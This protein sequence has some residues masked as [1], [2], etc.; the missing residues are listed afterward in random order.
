[1]TPPPPFLW[2][3]WGVPQQSATL[4]GRNTRYQQ[5]T[6]FCS[7][8]SAAMLSARA[9]ECLQIGA[10]V[11]VAT[12]DRIAKGAHFC[13]RRLPAGGLELPGARRRQVRSTNPVQSATITSSKKSILVHSLARAHRARSDHWTEIDAL[14][15]S[16]LQMMTSPGALPKSGVTR[17]RFS[18]R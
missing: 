11:C 14:R 13:M 10:E 2:A 6:Q 18:S 1:M 17:P 15:L 8:L 16:F 3:L 7:H 5:P 9:T 12:W 4:R